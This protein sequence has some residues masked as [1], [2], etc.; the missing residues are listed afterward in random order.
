MKAQKGNWFINLSYLIS[1]LDG[2]WV[3]NANTPPPAFLPP[4]KRP[5]VNRGDINECGKCR[6]PVGFDSQTVQPIASRNTDWAIQA[7]ANSVWIRKI[8]L[9]YVTSVLYIWRTWG[10][11]ISYII[12]HVAMWLYDIINFTPRG[13]YIVIYSYN[14]PNKIH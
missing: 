13:M 1:A 2:R 11:N 6:P 3:L 4:E 7:H 8:D 10:C 5:G 9:A 12:Y 14:K